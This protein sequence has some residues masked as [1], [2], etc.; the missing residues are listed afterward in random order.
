VS[1]VSES[2]V[3]VSDVQFVSMCKMFA[4]NFAQCTACI[5]YSAVTCMHCMHRKVLACVVLH[6]MCSVHEIFMQRMN[7]KQTACVKL[8]ASIL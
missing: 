3:V 5:T 4:Q 8:Y 1:D 7:R 2:Q 6:V